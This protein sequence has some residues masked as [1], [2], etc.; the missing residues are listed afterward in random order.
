M[1]SNLILQ[2]L[3][4]YVIAKAGE[5]LGSR[6]AL[7]IYRDCSWIL[8]RG[9]WCKKGGPVKFWSLISWG[10]LEKI[11]TNFPLKIEF[12]CFSMGLTQK[13]VKHFQNKFFFLHQAPLISV[14]EQSLIHFIIS[15]I[16][17]CSASNDCASQATCTNTV[18]TYTCACNTGYAGD[19]KTCS[20]K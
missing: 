5:T 13:G 3:Q 9:A 7:F 4:K 12:T 11:A 18:G 15:D 8:V 17:E 1:G 19:G 6:T 2:W 20:G 16:D 10:D 14:C